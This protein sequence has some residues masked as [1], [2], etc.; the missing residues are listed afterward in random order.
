[1]MRDE[2]SETWKS[3]K[4]TAERKNLYAQ[5][6]IAHHSYQDRLVK[7]NDRYHRLRNTWIESRPHSAKAEAESEVLVSKCMSLVKE[8]AHLSREWA[9]TMVKFQP[10][11]AKLRTLLKNASTKKVQEMEFEFTGLIRGELETG[12]P[13]KGQLLDKYELMLDDL[14]ALVGDGTAG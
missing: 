5:Y 4:V 7:L 11:R 12:L 3:S 8:S 1:M 13:K 2:P 9:E 6:Q 14:E 10:K